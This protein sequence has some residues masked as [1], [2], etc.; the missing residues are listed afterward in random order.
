MRNKRLT[1]GNTIMKLLNSAVMPILDGIYEATKLT[2]PEFCE[3]LIR[4]ADC[5]ELESFIGY[6]QNI[7]LIKAWTGVEVEL[8]SDSC[9]LDDID[10]MLVMKVKYRF[11]P[12]DKARVTVSPDDFEFAAIRYFR[13][14]NY[15]IDYDGDLI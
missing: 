9:I 12:A 11:N 15:G 6:Q 3:T 2:H 10:E 4:R 1:E 7:E 13:G 8:N 14:N 5:G